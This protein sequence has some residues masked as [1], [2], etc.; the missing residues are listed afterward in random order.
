MKP[1]KQEKVAYSIQ[2]VSKMLDVNASLLRYW[3]KE[4]PVIKPERSDKGTRT[5]RKD[6]IDTIKLIYHL[7]K[8]KGLTLEGAKQQLKTNKGKVVES[9]DII[10]RLKFVRSEL[11]TLLEE[12]V[13]MEKDINS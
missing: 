7:V 9:E 4:F 2:E 5:Y 8:E 12:I 11:K 3:E 13:G 10:S 1:F 6:D